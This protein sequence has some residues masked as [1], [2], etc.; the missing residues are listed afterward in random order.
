ML[1]KEIR[2]I[3]EDKCLDGQRIGLHIV[4]SGTVFKHR[5]SESFRDA[6]VAITGKLHTHCYCVVEFKLLQATRI[7]VLLDHLYLKLRLQNTE[8]CQVKIAKHLQGF[9]Q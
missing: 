4:T 3:L 6:A 7:R 9:V 1:H 2:V 5:L 8:I